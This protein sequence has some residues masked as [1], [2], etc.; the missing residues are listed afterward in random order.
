MRFSSENDSKNDE[1]DKTVRLFTHL[2]KAVRTCQAIDAAI[3]V[4]SPSS[5]K[6]PAGFGWPQ[7]Q[8]RRTQRLMQ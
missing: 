1:T 5:P 8:A 6:L 2:A 3:A 7:I 4:E